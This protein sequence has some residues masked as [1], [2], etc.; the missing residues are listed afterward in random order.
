MQVWKIK[1]ETERELLRQVD[2]LCYGPEHVEYV[3]YVTIKEG[4]GTSM[5]KLV[6]A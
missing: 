3:K 1:R 2:T 4:E 5:Y 6:G